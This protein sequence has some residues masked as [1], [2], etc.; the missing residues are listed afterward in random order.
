MQKKGRPTSITGPLGQLV[1]SVGGVDKLASLLNVDTRSIRHWA[2]NTRNPSG[3]AR[4]ILITLAKERGISI[5]Y[6]ND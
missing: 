1:E 6:N 3:P 4:T 2:N 5:S